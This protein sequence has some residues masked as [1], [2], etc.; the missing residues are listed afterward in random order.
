MRMYTRMYVCVSVRNCDVSWLL[1]VSMICVYIKQVH[2]CELM[3]RHACLPQSVAI[4]PFLSTSFLLIFVVAG[5]KY[6]NYEPQL[7]QMFE[8]ICVC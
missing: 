3:T 8:E 6:V 7:T 4:S 5:M 1:A 2:V